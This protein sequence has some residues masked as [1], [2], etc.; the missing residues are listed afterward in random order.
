[1]LDLRMKKIWIIPSA[2][3]AMNALIFIIGIILNLPVVGF[4]VGGT[5]AILTDP[6]IIISGLLIGIFASDKNIKVFLLMFFVGT[7][8]LTVIFHFYINTTHPLTDIIRF[9]SIL[10]ISSIIFLIKRLFI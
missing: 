7:I 4:L 10:I 8:I 5:A 1:M 3:I 2:I 9:N 6:I